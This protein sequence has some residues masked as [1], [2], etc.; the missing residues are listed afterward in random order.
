LLEH[1][2]LIRPTHT[3][4]MSVPGYRD[5][6]RGSGIR[7]FSD[8]T[9]L[10]VQLAG[11]E[12]AQLV[13]AGVH[14][15]GE[16]PLLEA[17]TRM[18]SI[19]EREP[20]WRGNATLRA[21]SWIDGSGVDRGF[22]VHEGAFVIGA[23]GSMPGLL[24]STAPGERVAQLSRLRK[25]V[26][27]RFSLEDAGHYLPSL[28]SCELQALYISVA[29]YPHAYRMSLGAEYGSANAAQHAAACLAHS[30]MQAPRLLA[31]LT[32]TSS[33]STPQ[34]NNYQLNTEVTRGDIEALFEE[35]GRGL[36]RS[37]RP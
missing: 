30:E 12:P 16:T 27:L 28:G 19:R 25:R 2:T 31:W 23:R 13:V 15:R 8:L 7:P 24:G 22:A 34:G 21:T 6:M 18:A 36:R 10:H 35:L 14:F 33:A 9:L 5:V 17:A 11:L 32:M 4:L 3:L 1:L 29:A 20:I 37:G 26:V